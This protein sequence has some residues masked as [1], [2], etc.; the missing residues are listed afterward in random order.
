VIGTDPVTENITLAELRDV[1]RIYPHGSTPVAA[2]NRVSL[3]IAPGEFVVVSGPS[4]S[5]KSTLLNIMGCL[6]RPTSGSVAIDGHDVSGLADKELT[7]IRRRR[8]GIIFQFFNLLPT[9]TALE[10]FALPLLLE[11]RSMK[12]VTPSAKDLLQRVGL[13]HRMSHHPDELSGGELQRVAVARALINRPVL[14]LADEPTGNLDTDN[15]RAIM[16][17]LREAGRAGGHALVVATHNPEVAAFADRQLRLRD[18]EV[19][20]DR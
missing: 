1:S 18:G 9:L 7:L 8:L 11:G 20:E 14:V 10:N 17:L 5:G 6:D 4:G 2:L 12:E 16:S 13:A 15:T 3:T 19:V